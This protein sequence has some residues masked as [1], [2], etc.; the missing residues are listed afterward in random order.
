MK[1]N[2][3]KGERKRRVYDISFKEQAVALAKEI[4][5]KEAK[6]KLGLKSEQVLGIWVREKNK[7]NAKDVD[8]EIAALREENKKLKKDLDKEKKI[9]AILKDAA[10]FFCQDNQK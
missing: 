7:K 6:D 1:A 5:L 10:A 3:L 2:R 8:A 9:T 4:G